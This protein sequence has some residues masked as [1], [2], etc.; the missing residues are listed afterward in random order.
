M[1][2]C[3]GSVTDH[4]IWLCEAIREKNVYVHRKIGSNWK[5]RDLKKREWS[6][7]KTGMDLLRK[8]SWSPF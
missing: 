8:Q 2:S 4:E 1:S 7:T 6:E 3:N 5:V